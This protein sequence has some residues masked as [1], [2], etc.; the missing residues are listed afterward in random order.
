MA[1]LILSRSAGG[2]GAA[3]AAGC[4]ESRGRGAEEEERRA[5]GSYRWVG[6]GGV[7][8]RGGRGAQNETSNKVSF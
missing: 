1:G 5:R 8:G 3:G 4:D 6:R 7:E 2:R